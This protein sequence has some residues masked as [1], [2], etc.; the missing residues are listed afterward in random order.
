MKMKFVLVI[1]VTLITGCVFGQDTKTF[2]KKIACSENAPFTGY[3]LSITYN[4][5][6][7]AQKELGFLDEIQ[8]TDNSKLKLIGQLLSF[9]KDKS[10]SC[11]KVTSYVFGSEGCRGFPDTVKRY[12][13]TIEALFLINKLCWPKSMEA[14]SCSPVLYDTLEK[15]VINNDPKA[16]SCFVKEYKKWYKESKK[17]GRISKEFPFN[18]GRYVWFG[19]RKYVKPEDNPALFN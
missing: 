5:Q 3:R 13:I 1:F 17:L 6:D 12:S 8:L 19:G 15:R 4:E 11:R 18:T 9:T 7:N 2:V 16:I 14:Y 10:L